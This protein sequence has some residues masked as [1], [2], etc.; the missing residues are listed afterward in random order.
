MLVGLHPPR[1]RVDLLS[2]HGLLAPNATWRGLELS[3]Y[4]EADL[5]LHTQLVENTFSTVPLSSLVQAPQLL[6]T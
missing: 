4:A 2:Y 3:A 6:I 5:K 1:Q